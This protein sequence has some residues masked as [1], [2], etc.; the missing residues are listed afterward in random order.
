[1]LFL[2]F[3]LVD[4]CSSFYVQLLF[5]L[6]SIVVM[7]EVF[8]YRF[9]YCCHARSLHVSF[10]P[11]YVASTPLQEMF[12]LKLLLLS[13]ITKRT[14]WDEFWLFNLMKLMTLLIGYFVIHPKVF[15]SFLLFIAF[16]EHI[17]AHHFLLSSSLLFCSF[18]SM[19]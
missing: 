2:C 17:I 6:S 1:M 5:L 14:L 16:S 10:L 19:M 11:M 13:L 18:F 3:L 7:L 8:M 15:F 9:F 4:R 12:I